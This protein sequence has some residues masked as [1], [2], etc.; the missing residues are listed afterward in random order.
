[1]AGHTVDKKETKKILR[2]FTG[3]F[4]K[5]T[6]KSESRDEKYAKL[7]QKKTPLKRKR[8]NG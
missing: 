1:M 8:T 3:I 4:M 2:E 6:L 7:A 5:G